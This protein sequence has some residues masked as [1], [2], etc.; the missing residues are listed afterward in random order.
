MPKRFCAL[1]ALAGFCLARPA[2]ADERVPYQ[3][4]RVETLLLLD[5]E[6]DGSMEVT[7]LVDRLF[8]RLQPSGEDL[9][10]VSGDTRTKFEFRVRNLAIDDYRGSRTSAET[11]GLAEYDGGPPARWTITRYGREEVAA[12]RA[13]VL[14]EAEGR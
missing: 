2:E 6:P 7:E 11:R 1:L 5:A 13:R 4:I 12:W 8:E 14:A 3:E 9:E 10:A